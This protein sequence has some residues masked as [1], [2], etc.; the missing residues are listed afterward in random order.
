MGKKSKNNGKNK[1]PILAMPFYFIGSIFKNMYDDIT[2]TQEYMREER[3]KAR[4]KEE[5]EQEK[6]RKKAEQEF[7]ENEQFFKDLEHTEIILEDAYNA[8]DYDVDKFCETKTYKYYQP[9]YNQKLDKFVEKVKKKLDGDEL[10]LYL[11]LCRKAY[12]TAQEAA[13]YLECD[14]NH[15][16]YILNSLC[17]RLYISKFRRDNTTYYEQYDS[18]WLHE[19]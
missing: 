7:K 1:M 16:Y 13:N 18:R 9:I 17:D 19:L 6:A 5:E 8:C 14:Y 10:R 12:I 2:A 11:F 4:K 3:E 15:A